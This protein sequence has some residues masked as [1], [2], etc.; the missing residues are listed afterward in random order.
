MPLSK[1]GIVRSQPI[2]QSG[3]LNTKFV[4]VNLASVELQT[5]LNV[6]VELDLRVNKRNGFI[7][8]GDIVP[9]GGNP[10]SKIQGFGEYQRVD[11]SWVEWVVRNGK[12]YVRN[13][14][15]SAWTN[16]ILPTDFTTTA[17]VNGKDVFF[18]TPTA[19]VTGTTTAPFDSQS[20][21]DTTKTWVVDAYKD[22]MVVITGGTGIG[23]WAKISSNTTNKLIFFNVFSII[24][25]GTSTYGIYD[26]DKILI[27]GDG[28][29][30]LIRYDG[31]SATTIV[32]SPKGNIFTEWQQRLV[33]AGVLNDINTAHF[34]QIG[35]P[36]Y[37]VINSSS[38]S[39][40]S[41]Q[42]FTSIKGKIVG[43]ATMTL[44]SERLLVYTEKTLYDIIYSSGIVVRE[45][46]LSFGG[47]NY[48]GITKVDGNPTNIASDYSIRIFGNRTQLSSGVT[49]DD[50]GYKIS[51]NIKTAY[52][53]T[54]SSAVYLDKNMYIALQENIGSTTNDVIYCYNILKNIWTKFNGNYV[55]FKQLAIIENR[56]C[57]ASND[58]YIYN[59]RLDTDV[60]RF[61]DGTNTPINAVIK[62]K[63]ENLGSSNEKTFSVCRAWIGNRGSITSSVTLNGE[64]K[65]YASEIANT[66]LYNKISVVPI[67]SSGSTNKQSCVYKQFY[68]VKRGSTIAFEFSNNNLNEDFSL[69]KIEIGFTLADNR[70]STL[71]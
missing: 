20:L 44:D 55:S 56:L 66:T 57:G 69:L 1:N 34:S 63:D 31:N 68:M 65:K 70:S 35:N 60:N 7:N 2:T 53:L 46:D 43:L 62:T 23:Q 10:A 42:N 14:G 15:V 18:H 9:D 13:R 71:K 45:R 22:K 5:A 17:E 64:V 37:F 25:D 52:N 27:L 36:E 54:N 38:Y 41:P 19:I 16:K 39:P 61:V 30:E 29:H 49:I 47:I 40:A 48:R 67:L 51:P 32:N 3:G 58:G 8:R 33:V 4:S 50:I 28:V 26:I 11:N 21:T 6:I 24:P 59:Q 12:L